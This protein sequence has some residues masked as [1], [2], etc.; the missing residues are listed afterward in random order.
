MKKFLYTYWGDF[1]FGVVLVLVW[2]FA[3]LETSFE[4]TIIG[5]TAL[6][7]LLLSI[8]ALLQII[9]F[10]KRHLRDIH[11]IIIHVAI[12][13]LSVGFL[14]VYIPVVAML[15]SVFMFAASILA[16]VRPSIWLYKK[17]QAKRR[18]TEEENHDGNE[19]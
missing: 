12:F 6:M 10:K 1:S 13:T 14:P 2:I 3:L 5:I 17:W 18:P 9:L 15:S 7:G 4:Q 16:T 11:Y 8:I 19:E